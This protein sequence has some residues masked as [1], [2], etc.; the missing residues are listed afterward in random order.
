MAVQQSRNV[1][2]PREC[3][4]W[5]VIARKVLYAVNLQQHPPKGFSYCGCRRQPLEHQVQQR[6]LQCQNA[7]YQVGCVGRQLHICVCEVCEAC[8][9]ADRPQMVLIAV[10]G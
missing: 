6:S 10:L 2:L 3:L 5:V 1:V 9:K 4:V 7:S 8:S